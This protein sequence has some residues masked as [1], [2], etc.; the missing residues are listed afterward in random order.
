M[1]DDQV[2][3]QN[4][5]VQITSKDFEADLDRIPADNRVEVLASRD[6]I[7]KLLETLLINKTMAARARKAGIDHEPG[8]LK[9]LELADDKVLADEEIKRATD[10]AAIPDFE[11][12]ASEIYKIN[13]EKFTIPAEVH[14]SHILVAINKDRSAEDA[15]KRIQEVR[16]QALA[17]KSFADLALEYSDDPSVKNNKGDLG[18]FKA[19]TMIKSFSDVAFAMNTPEQISEPVQTRFGYHIIQFHEKHPE[20][21]RPY[22]EVKEGILK[23]LRDKYLAD[24]RMN[25]TGDI[26][27]DPD[28]KFDADAVDK[29]RTELPAVPA[30]KAA[31]GLPPLPAMQEEHHHKLDGSAR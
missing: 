15:L 9:R 18:F 7:R 27:S 22:A 12:R 29:F 5:D 28:L 6:R 13:S 11:Q 21:I 14:A 3:V 25:L 31:T 20:T 30:P 1:A 16:K 4:K 17:G 19:S 8:M 10:Q 24:F 23:E 26:L 2:L